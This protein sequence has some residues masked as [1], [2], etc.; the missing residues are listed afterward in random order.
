MTTRTVHL[1]IFD[2]LADWEAGYAI[3]RLNQ[4]EFQKVPHEV[5]T[6]GLTRAPVR[7]MGG[8]TMTPDLTLDEVRA[9]DS[10]MLILPGGAVWDGEGIPAAV[11]KARA[12]LAA[13]VPV[14]AICGATAGLAREGLLDDRDHTSNAA[15]YLQATGYKGGAR[16][17]QVP[18][19][20]DGNLVTASSIGAL[21]FAREIFTVL[22]VYPKEVT[23]AWFGLFKTGEAR[24]FHAL[25]ELAQQA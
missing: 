8:V 6:V 21:E 5:R 17:K 12:L 4:P 22:D 24:Y 3:A 11:E 19:V 7:S 1:F 23:D 15:E 10:A 2:T 16:Y 9:E 25:M 20:S 13:G 18:A 14:A